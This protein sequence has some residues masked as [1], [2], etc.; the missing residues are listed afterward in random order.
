MRVP[1][2]EIEIVVPPLVI[3]TPEPFAVHDW[4]VELTLVFEPLDE[5]CELCTLT[6][7][8]AHE[9]PLELVETLLLCCCDPPEL[10]WLTL[11]LTWQPP[12]GLVEPCAAFFAELACVAPT[13]CST[14]IARNLGIVAPPALWGALAAGVAC[15]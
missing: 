13:T 15:A 12:V 1:P 4:V 3:C 2:L 7:Q 5:L 8:V 6:T 9:P 10:D 14:G 11:M